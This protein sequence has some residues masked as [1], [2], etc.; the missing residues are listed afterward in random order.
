[1]LGWGIAVYHL[2]D[3]GANPATSKSQLGTRIAVWQTWIYGLDWINKLVSEGKAINL[4]GNGYPVLYTAKAEHLIPPILSGP[5]LAKEIWG[6][7]HGDILLEG[8]EG[9]TVINQ[10][11]VEKCRPDEW[12]MFE[13]FDES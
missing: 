7:D 1:M 13:A 4:G 5:P 3:G 6:F 8:W 10:E 2:A 9:K 11:E 12:L